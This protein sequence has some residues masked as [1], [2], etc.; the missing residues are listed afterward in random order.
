MKTCIHKGIVLSEVEEGIRDILFENGK[1]IAIGKDLCTSADHVVDASGCYVFPGGVDEHT[2]FGSFGSYSFET[3]QAAALGGTTTVVDFVDQKEQ[4]S[5]KD[6][7][8][9]QIKKADTYPYVH[10][11]FH[12]MLMDMRE[13]VLDEIQNL[14][15]YGISTLKLFTAYKGTAYYADDLHILEVMKRIKDTGLTL[16]IHAENADMIACTTAD[17]LKQGYI[18][19]YY[20]AVARDPM[21]EAEM[22]QRMIIYASWIGIPLFFVHISTKEALKYITAA[23]QRGQPV[24]CETCTHYLVLDK[25]KLAEEGLQGCR[26]ICS[27][28]LRG[29]SDQDALWEGIRNHTIEAVSSDH[30]AILGG[31]ERKIENY[32]DF[33]KVPNGAPG[34]QHRLSMLWSEGVCKGRISKQDFV[35]VFSS[36]PADICNLQGKGRIL[37]GYDADIVIYDPKGIHI[38]CDQDSSE[39]CGYATFAGM[40]VQGQVREVYLDGELIVE[41]GSYVGKGNGRVLKSEPFGYCTRS[42]TFARK[43]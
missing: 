38:L 16:M 36:R 40:Q 42:K 3:S 37:P 9:F 29:K 20:H 18:E 39:G 43:T 11:A 22:V 24:Y 30:C 31:Y 32:T 8:S 13:E 23:Q 34:V 19:P 4:Q 5:L 1:I 41:K 25:T 17:L 15:S 26:Y 14:N 2:H 35:R 7:L 10:V 28:P 12:S 33:S 27:P 6:A 21:S